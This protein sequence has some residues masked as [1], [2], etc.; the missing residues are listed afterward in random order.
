MFLG[1]FGYGMMMCWG[2]MHFGCLVNSHFVD[3]GMMD[4]LGIVVGCLTCFDCGFV[5]L[6][7]GNFIGFGL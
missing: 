5:C 7:V 3:D 1:Y 4:A 6:W 2:N